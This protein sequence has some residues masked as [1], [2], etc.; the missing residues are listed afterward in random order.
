MLLFMVDPTRLRDE[1]RRMKSLIQEDPRVLARF[2]QDGNGVIDGDE[3]EAVRQLVIRRLEREEEEARVAPA[4]APGSGAP[5]V[6]EVALE[7][8][9]QDLLTPLDDAGLGAGLLSDFVLEQKGGLAAQLA[10]GTVRRRY[11]VCTRSGQP[12]A[13]IEQVE[14]QW[15]QTLTSKD[16]SIP[17]LHFRVHDKRTDE[18]LTLQK[19]ISGGPERIS[20]LLPNASEI[21]HTRFVGQILQREAMAYSSLKPLG[22]K[23]KRRLLKPWTYDIKTELDE[24]VGVV[25]RGWSGLGGFL[26]GGN[27]MHVKVAPERTSPEL[28]WAL[29]AAALMFDLDAEAK[30]STTQEGL[31]DSILRR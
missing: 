1:L 27:R 8:L 14:N 3:W 18:R 17:D 11:E 7:I 23:V 2:D 12:V 26:S 21:A 24:C 5:P 6:G 22:L 28:T 30:S 20:V 19:S 13:T 31:L 16:L 15:L 10:E 9:E 29:I 25:E 4:P